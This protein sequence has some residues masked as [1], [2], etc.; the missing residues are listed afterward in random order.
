MVRINIDLPTFKY[1]CMLRTWLFA[2]VNS[3]V[4]AD[5]RK[6]ERAGQSI[7]PPFDPYDDAEREDDTFPSSRQKQ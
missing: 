3:C 1:Q 6:F 5:Y 4:I 2:I 7:A